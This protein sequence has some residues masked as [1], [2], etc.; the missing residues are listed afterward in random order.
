MPPGTR[1][2]LDTNVVLDWV[3]FRDSGVESLAQAIHSGAAV[4]VSTH[5]CLEELR[6][7]LAYPQLK[8]DLPGRLTAFECYRAQVQLVEVPAASRAPLPQCADPDD[9][10]FLEL[11]WHSH[12]RCLITKDKALLRLARAA[13]RAGRFVVVKPGNFDPHAAH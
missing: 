7:V 11:A 12:A 9:Q 8:L 10:K 1:C 4:P 2:V 6:R 3:V 5:D 13:A